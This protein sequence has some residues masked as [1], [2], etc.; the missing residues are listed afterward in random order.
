M[1][2]L[3]LLCYSHAH[4]GSATT[5]CHFTEA[6]ALCVLME[7]ERVEDSRLVELKFMEVQ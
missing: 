6:E 5:M 7:P 2:I 3:H 1:K 4:D